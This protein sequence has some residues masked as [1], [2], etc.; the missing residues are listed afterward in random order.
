M[1]V[2]AIWPTTGAVARLHCH[3]GSHPPRDRSGHQGIL[4]EVGE[5]PGLTTQ[6]HM[7][8]NRTNQDCTYQEVAHLHC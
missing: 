2:Q 7:S 8:T 1:Y 3:M 6:P 5:N 4:D